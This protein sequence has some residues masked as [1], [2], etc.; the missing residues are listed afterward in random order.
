MK[1]SFRR[2]DEGLC[3]DASALIF[4]LL[5][6][7]VDS[8]QGPLQFVDFRLDSL[9]RLRGGEA[10]HLGYEVSVCSDSS[11]AS[12]ASDD[13]IISRHVVFSVEN[14]PAFAPRRDCNF[15]VRHG[16]SLNG[17]RADGPT[18]H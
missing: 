14:S 18:L 8:L 12:L 9:S 3:P 7:Q 15:A 10:F 2:S 1:V 4:D 16:P 11:A 13:R 5:E 6:L 17:S